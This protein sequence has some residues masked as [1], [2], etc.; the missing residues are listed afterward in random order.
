MGKLH[1][2]D[3]DVSNLVKPLYPYHGSEWFCET[4]QE[5]AKKEDKTYYPLFKGG[6][7]FN[8]QC[9]LR[10][11]KQNGVHYDPKKVSKPITAKQ[12]H[13]YYEDSFDDSKTQIQIITAEDVMIRNDVVW[14]CGEQ[15]YFTDTCDEG[16]KKYM[17]QEPPT[18][19]SQDVDMLFY[20]NQEFGF[21]HFMIEQLPRIAFFLPFLR[22]NPDIRICFGHDQQP[23]KIDS[24]V[25]GINLLANDI[26]KQV[27]VTI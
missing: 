14:S 15:V 20:V 22:D 9:L 12:M 4:L 8:E 7:D 17:M 13:T 26:C 21:T 11:F 25:A 5:Y 16:S 18:V 24:D 27:R 3:F 2:I 6:W 1:R 10:N 19:A 23:V